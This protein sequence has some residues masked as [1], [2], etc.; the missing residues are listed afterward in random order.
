M[1]LCPRKEGGYVDLISNSRADEI[2]RESKKAAWKPSPLCPRK[3]MLVLERTPQTCGVS[4]PCTLCSR[5][6][7]TAMNKTSRNAGLI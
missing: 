5:C 3:N 6:C 7:E 4:V 1:S 2:P